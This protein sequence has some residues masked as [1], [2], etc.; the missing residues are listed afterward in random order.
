[1]PAWASP[2]G[3]VIAEVYGGGGNSGAP[4]QNDF[5]VLFNGGTSP[6]NANGWSIQYASA[7]GSTW[8]VAALTNNTV[9]SPGGYFLVK[10]GSGGTNGAPLPTPDSTPASINMSSSSGKVA[11]VSNTTPLTGT[12]PA[13]GSIVDF[14][15]YGTANCYEGA[16][17][18]A[19]SNTTS[20]QR[21]NGGCMDTDNNQS[22]FK[23]A[24]PN[25][26]N[27]ASPLNVCSAPPT[28]PQVPLRIA[29]VDGSA[30]LSW[31]DPV[32]SLAFSSDVAGTYN[33]I[34]GA[35]SPYTNT[36]DGSAK[37]F[38]LVWP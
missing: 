2:S 26:R 9:I 13:D 25:P 19:L 10:L 27:S 32:F 23:V 6:V 24:A 28:P 20:A 21:N 3:L 11:L 12:C 36:I 37:F 1:M 17:T 14:A 7:T 5:V 15:G 34:P 16:A 18:P 8:H 30:V 35:T 29:V 38:R 4:Y 22:D 33:K 31:S